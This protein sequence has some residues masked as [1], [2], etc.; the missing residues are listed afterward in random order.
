MTT[1]KEKRKLAIKEEKERRLRLAG[2]KK[3]YRRG[4]IVRG[5]FWCHER[6]VGHTNLF[7]AWKRFTEN[8]YFASQTK[9]QLHP[10]QEK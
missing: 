9:S 10:N 1:K 7:G 8:D 4:S 6:V 2:W 3:E 5:Y